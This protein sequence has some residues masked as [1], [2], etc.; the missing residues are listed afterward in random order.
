M[1]VR[2]KTVFSASDIKSNH[3]R[4]GRIRAT[5]L[6]GQ[7]CN[8]LSTRCV[9][10]TAQYEASDNH[11]PLFL[12]G[13]F[14]RLTSTNGSIHNLLQCQTLLLVLLGG[15]TQLRVHHTV[16]GK[17][18]YGLPRY[19]FNSVFCLHDRAGVGECL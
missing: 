3:I 4:I 8:F 9:P 13:L 15:E 7:L 14:T 17:I 19:A 18:F 5:V 1:L 2:G 16:C 10:H 6:D 11:M 12:C